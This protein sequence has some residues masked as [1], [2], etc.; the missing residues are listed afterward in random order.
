[1]NPWYD[2]DELKHLLLPMLIREDE[3]AHEL[4]E[5]ET[6]PSDAVPQAE[7]V[8]NALTKFMQKRQW[9]AV[10]DVLTSYPS[11]LSE[12]LRSRATREACR[13][14]SDFDLRR[15]VHHCPDD[16]LD[17][18]L[19]QLVSCNR[20]QVVKQVLQRGILNRQQRRWVMRQ[21]LQRSL[22]WV[23]SDLLPDYADDVPDRLL[24][25]LTR[26][27]MWVSVSKVLQQQQ[28][29][30]PP[31]RV[32]DAER[33]WVIH[34]AS[35]VATGFL[36]LQWIFPHCGD[37]QV[38]SVLTQLVTLGKWQAVLG[39][40]RQRREVIRATRR[41]WAIE[42]A[43]ERAPDNQL[44]LDIISQCSPDWLES[45][46]V[47][48]VKRG[49]WEAAREV[50]E[51][52]VGD[53]VYAWAVLQAS[54]TASEFSVKRLVEI[55]P[56]ERVCRIVI[57]ACQRGMP[58]VAEKMLKRVGWDPLLSEVIV[59]AASFTQPKSE[60]TQPNSEVTQPK[61][62]VTQPNSE[63]TQPNSEVTQP[64]TLNREIT[65]P[66]SEVTQ[67]D[68]EVT[69]PN[70]DV[71]QPDSEVT[72][73]NSEMTQPDSEHIDTATDDRTRS[74]MSFVCGEVLDVIAEN[75]ETETAKT[76]RE[77]P[78]ISQHLANQIKEW[79]QIFEG[80]DRPSSL[81]TSSFEFFF[82][83]Y[84]HSRREGQSTGDHTPGSR[85]E[86]PR[87][88]KDRH[89][90]LALTVLPVF[91]ELQNAA[92]AIMQRERR[93]DVISHACLTHAWEQVRRE[94]L[95]A[96]AEQGQWAVVKRW[97]DHSLYD[98]QRGWA[99]QEAFK[100]KQWDVFLL[101]ADHGLERSELMRVHYRLAKYAGWDVVLRLLERGGD[102]AELAELLQATKRGE[103]NLADPSAAACYKRRRIRLARLW[104]KLSG[105]S[106]ADA[107]AAVAN[108]DWRLVLFRLQQEDRDVDV[109]RAA[110][111]ALR[112]GA[113]HVLVQLARLGMDA[114]QRDS[115]FPEMVRRRQ[116]GV[117]RALLERGL[118]VESCLA[119][120]PELMKMNQWILLARVME[121]D[122]GD[123]V[124]RQILQHA[125]ERK[126]G[127]M[128]AHFLGT[129]HGRLSVEEREVLFQQSLSRGVW[130]ALKPLVQEKDSTGIAHRD[131]AMQKA[132]EQGQWDVVDHCERYY[133]DINKH[134]S[135]GDTPLLRAARRADWKAVEELV[136][137][138]CDQF[139]LDSDGSSVLH[140]ALEAGQ[141][142]IAKLL[143][144][145]HGDV[146]LPDRDGVTPLQMLI[147]RR[148]ADIID[149]MLFWQSDVCT[150][151]YSK[152]GGTTLHAACEAGWLRTLYYL[153]A[154]RVDPLAVTE[155][156]ESVL[157]LAVQNT[158]CPQRL[159][160][161]CIRLGFSTHQPLITDPCYV[162]LDEGRKA[163]AVKAAP[164]VP[165]VTREMMAEIQDRDLWDSENFSPFHFALVRD[166]PV[167]RDM[168]YE[169]GACSYKELFRLY[170]DVSEG[171]S[172][173]YDVTT[174]LPYLRKVATTPRS[175]RSAC[176]LVISHCLDV[177]G[178]RHQDV[179]YLDL[180]ESLKDYVMFSDLT[181]PDFGKDRLL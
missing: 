69:Q 43:S 42:E 3:I 85:R 180:E 8:K 74:L 72:Q 174:D 92:L 117:C 55:W 178:K 82:T 2:G 175:L 15:L 177:R 91:P 38:E 32:S 46:L 86:N 17:A 96:A 94:L 163:R 11:L 121:H 140:K 5:L 14:T 157:M 128:V 162:V 179:E 81:Q 63:V 52:G 57:L 110:E 93:W 10:T 102:L 109:S 48:L 126:E 166:M 7:R 45:V 131:I 119:A 145:F 19:P 21:A 99:L 9:D 28:Q 172:F 127:S 84:Y 124:R 139:V 136:R 160:A 115:F 158:R 90:L 170:T 167:V 18:L 27:A 147:E 154:R 12:D 88:S 141:P 176:R 125:M 113:W 122:V 54:L 169:S 123:A 64:S 13:H 16:Q 161:E 132:A 67:P 149:D 89:L 95:R 4:A 130:Q 78:H 59:S 56:E 173:C 135:D 73:P 142:A 37:D 60:V 75:T 40:L 77:P 181:D 143:I 138:G 1:M 168:L 120:L 47:K 83:L 144:Q 111:A 114:A 87:P 49:A 30:Q 146:N 101:L 68:S 108:S 150:G 106:V 23:I 164:A 44:L 107:A 66:N 39:V 53:E 129:T 65:Q 36:F 156:R 20:W 24:A 6:P 159:V 171:R 98:D 152:S 112:S 25:G 80:L 61:S 134:N 97:A 31:L 155:D 148:H 29:P 153:L 165:G 151:G 41:K 70:S 105:S 71:T 118:R 137:R 103:K 50:A 133:A 76:G 100:E 35:R 34:K 51:R 104:R 22:D 116:W 58:S 26:R 62:E 79:T 33:R